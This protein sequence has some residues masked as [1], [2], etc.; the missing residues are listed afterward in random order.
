MAKAKAKATK[1]KI[2]KSSKSSSQ[3]KYATSS[4]SLL[5]TKNDVS[6]NTSTTPYLSRGQ[7]KR[8]TKKDQQRLKKQVMI[9]SSLKLQKLNESK[10]KIDGFEGFKE[11]ID[12]ITTTSVQEKKQ[13]KNNDNESNYT[14]NKSKQNL[15]LKEVTHMNLV[16]QH[17]TFQSNPFATIQEHL[18]NTNIALQ[19]QSNN[20]NDNDI[21]K[22]KSKKKKKKKVSNNDVM[23]PNKKGM[24]KKFK[25]RKVTRLKKR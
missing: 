20:N 10:N 14:T 7:R 4:S 1:A 24:A 2:A 21:D 9:L 16:L 5:T 3:T 23:V 12:D 17:P 8:Q 11:A 18:R 15:L 19:E 13:P 6:T 25:S 22:E